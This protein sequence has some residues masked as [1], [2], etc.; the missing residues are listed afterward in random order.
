MRYVL[1]TQA[2]LLHSLRDVPANGSTSWIGDPVATEAARGRWTDE[3]TNVVDHLGHL[4]DEVARFQAAVIDLDAPVPA[5]PDWRVRDLVHHVGSVHRMFRRVADEGWLERPPPLDPD[6]RPIAE[7]D[8]VFDWSR[9]QAAGLL[10]ALGRLDPEAPRWNFT[11]GPQVGGFIPRRM[12][13]ETTIHRWDVEGAHGIR[14]HLDV[15]VARDGV[16][17]YLE[18]LRLRWG[19]WGGVPAVVRTELDA[20][21]TIDLVLRSGEVPDV[22]I[23]ADARG[24]GP[25]DGD[26]ASGTDEM[27]RADVV[28]RT[29]PVT[30]YLAWWGRLPLAD[31]ADRGE[32]ALIGEIRTY[33]RT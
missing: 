12:L 21:P 6:D 4:R 11:T 14:G 16:R 24:R 5:C 19:T 15:E 23:D 29:D 3:G 32:P 1:R 9:E 25:Q 8:R 18:A 30:A 7:D 31:I 17:E 33:A 27:A 13:H 22:L 10:E 26:W 20:G 2:H 28:L